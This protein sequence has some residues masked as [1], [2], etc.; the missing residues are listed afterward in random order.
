L[1]QSGLA[2]NEIDYLNTHGSSSPLGD[3]VEIQAIEQ[4]FGEYF[5]RVRLNA[6]KGLTGHCLYSAGVVETIATVMQMQQGFIHANLNLEN[7]I[8]TRANFCGPTAVS[9]QIHTTMSNSFG[10]GGINTS[11]V[12]QKN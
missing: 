3:K 7:P 8:N 10:F 12:L 2:A 9:Q 5:A 6:T 1:Q 4:V 11:I